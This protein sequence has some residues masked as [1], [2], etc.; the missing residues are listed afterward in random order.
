MKNKIRWKIAA[1]KK[2]ENWR[3]KLE[4]FSKIGNVS[5]QIIVNADVSILALVSVSTT[6]VLRVFE[7][8]DDHLE[9]VQVRPPRV[10]DVPQGQEVGL[11]SRL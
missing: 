7:S 9:P 5:Y 4:I 8:R 11:E 2:I 1:V 6:F 3:Q 10:G